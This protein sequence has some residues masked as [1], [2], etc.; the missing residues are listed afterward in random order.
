MAERRA[1]VMDGCGL[2]FKGERRDRHGSSPGGVGLGAR[3]GVFAA[4]F[5]SLFS[6]P[7]ASP[8]RA[9]FTLRFSPV[10]SRQMSRAVATRCSRKTTAPARR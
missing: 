5:M 10:S 3:S 1:L 6:T 2:D 8:L 7:V 4:E 9:V